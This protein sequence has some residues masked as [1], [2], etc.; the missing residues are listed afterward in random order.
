MKDRSLIS[1][2]NVYSSY[3][4]LYHSFTLTRTDRCLE[5]PKSEKRQFFN[6]R[7]FS[8]K[9]WELFNK[10]NSSIAG[11]QY[12]YELTVYGYTIL[13]IELTSFDG[14]MRQIDYDFSIEDKTNNYRLH[15]SELSASG[16][17]TNLWHIHQWNISFYKLN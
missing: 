9:N 4:Y 12:I 1:V 7:F 6:H 13:R 15:I 11:N 5:Q 10:V 17:G 2:H 16:I 8:T 3:I 14:E